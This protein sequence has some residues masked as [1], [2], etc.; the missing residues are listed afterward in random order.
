MLIGGGIGIYLL[1]TLMNLFISQNDLSILERL[2]NIQDDGGSGRDFVWAHTWRMI[3]EESNVLS[4]LFG[5]G[6]NAVY[7]DS[8][9]E[10]SAH[11]DFLE[12]IYDYGFIGLLLYFALYVQ[13]F[14]YYKRIKKHLPNVAG[15]FAASIAMALC[16]SM[17]A[18]LVINPILFMFLCLF[19][20]LYIGECDKKIKQKYG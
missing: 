20:G 19:W 4:L 15:A 16:I 10:L 18:H 7:S 12:I 8:M 11:N 17:V 14:S 1:I 6:F 13:L 9:L 3:T 5:H 2:G